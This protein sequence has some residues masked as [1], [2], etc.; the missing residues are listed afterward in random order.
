MRRGIEFANLYQ[1]LPWLTLDA[2]VAISNA[3]F[4]NNPDDQGTL[5]PESID[6]VTSAG[7]TADQ[8]N[9]AASV[10]LRYFGPRVLD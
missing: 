6:A 9:Y 5:V 2:D 1:P 8:L 10:R 3:R 4:L 7:V